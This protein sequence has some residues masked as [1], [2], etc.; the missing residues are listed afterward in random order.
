MI[1]LR[2]L[3]LNEMSSTGGPVAPI[4]GSD[5][6]IG[7]IILKQKTPKKKYLN[8]IATKKLLSLTTK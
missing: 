5:K 2:Y 4:G 8:E 1:N 3:Q 6:P 7:G